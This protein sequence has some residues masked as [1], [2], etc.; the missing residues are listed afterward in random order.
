VE[1]VLCGFNHSNRDLFLHFSLAHLPQLSDDVVEAPL[2]LRSAPPFVNFIYRMLL[3]KLMHH[4]A[5]HHLL[6][7]RKGWHWLIKRSGHFQNNGSCDF[8]SDIIMN[9]KHLV[10]PSSEDVST[11]LEHVMIILSFA[12]YAGG[13]I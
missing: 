1:R 10:L 5:S 8:Q 2:H 12:L 4:H 6:G 3:P 11:W 7:C 13:R 9:G